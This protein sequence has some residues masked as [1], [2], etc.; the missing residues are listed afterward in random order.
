MEEPV[1]AAKK[2]YRSEMAR[3]RRV[4]PTQYFTNGLSAAHNPSM[5]R[6]PMDRLYP[7]PRDAAAR[8]QGKAALATRGGGGRGGLKQRKNSAT[9]KRTPLLFN[10]FT[11]RLFLQQFRVKIGKVA[12]FESIHKINWT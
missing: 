9:R 4:P 10:S 2:K 8:G 7:R 12:L 1:M 5:S 3:P 6:I 11:E